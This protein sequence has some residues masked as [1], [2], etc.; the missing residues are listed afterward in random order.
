MMR[1][2]PLILSLL[3]LLG[4]LA[5][6][7]GAERGAEE[8][9][10]NSAANNSQQN[11]TQNNNNNS[12]N[13]NQNNGVNN[14]ANNGANNSAN[15]GAPASRWRG[16]VVI[17]EV[18]AAGDPTDQVELYNTSDASV[19]LSGWQVTDTPGDAATFAALPEGTTLPAKGYLLL[20]VSDDT[21]GFKLGGDEAFA[22][23]A[24]DGT[25]IDVADWDEGDSPAGGSWARLPDG[26]GDFQTTDAPTPGAPN[27]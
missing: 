27:E 15:N 1:N 19:D 4:A 20:E 21:L 5:A 14:G 13:N 2:V 9:S 11:N 26:A 10:N 18:I 23:Y 7:S 16:V 24:P 3:S 25:L 8:G 12:L 6:C 22:L 17:N